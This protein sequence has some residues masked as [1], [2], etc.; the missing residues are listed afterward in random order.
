MTRATLRKRCR[1]WVNAPRDDCYGWSLRVRFAVGERLNRDYHR[2][3]WAYWQALQC[4][5]RLERTLRRQDARQRN[6]AKRKVA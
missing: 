2:Y 1:T 6:R 3:L 4:Q 5:H